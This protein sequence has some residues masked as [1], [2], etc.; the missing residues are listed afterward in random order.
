M[1][2]LSFDY[3]NY[4]SN[5]IDLDHLEIAK[6]N[7]DHNSKNLTKKN[8]GQFYTPP[9]IGIPL[10]K[11]VAKYILNL[12]KKIISLI[13]PFCGDGRLIVWLLENTSQIEWDIVIWD[14]D[15]EALNI[16]YK[17]ISQAAENLSKKVKLTFKKVDTFNEF[18][19]NYERAFDVIITN[20]PWDVVKPD[21]NEL[22]H[23]DPK[24]KSNYITSL[25]QFSTRLLN[26]YPLSRPSQAY[27]GWGVNLARVGTEIAIRLAKE[28]G[29][30]AIVSPASLLA[31]QNS[32]K[33][34]EWLFENNHCK[35]VSF[36]PAESR[37]FKGV[38]QP[39]ISLIIIKAAQ[40][41]G[42]L[43]TSYGKKI[44]DVSQEKLSIPI[45]FLKSIDYKL[46]VS[47]GFKSKHINQLV[48][49]QNLP[50]FQDLE[51]PRL[52]GLW[53][54]RELDETNHKS[55]LT[56]NGKH[57]FLK[58]RMV[59]RFSNNLTSKT[60]V[61][62]I[63]QSDIP[64]SVNYH[65]IVWRDVSRPSQKRRVIATLIPPKWVTGNS[66]GVAY[67]KYSEDRTMLL[68]LLGIMSSL[69]F[70]FQV[71]SLLATAH[72]SVGILRKTHIP[73][74]SDTEFVKLISSLVRERLEG[75][76]D[77]ESKLEVTVAKA[78]GLS[79]DDFATITDAFPKISEEYRNSLLDIK[80]WSQI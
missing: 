3:F 35:E 74:L 33:L 13:D 6:N 71:R 75:R 43:L 30:V 20:P 26:D 2:Q 50:F 28:G 7:I 10:A 8:T 55:W 23:L 45:S 41:N 60:F 42:I 1:K 18:Q 19:N 15:E 32:R 39:S 14:Y 12:N 61:S 51:D 17:K 58:G 25:K 79:R 11:N 73:K 4:T 34:R 67:F 69:V 54:G 65:R 5:T 47:F 56:L 24:A 40:Q 70:E 62:E 57:P 63:K 68:A 76:E 21:T 48:K 49:F 72:I 27:G 64:S 36:F 46:P 38:D 52:G 16:A 80:T 31:D 59:D 66:L 22:S 53:S 29:V 77:I 44:T 37:L 9:E 78:Y